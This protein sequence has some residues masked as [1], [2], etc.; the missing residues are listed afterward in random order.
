LTFFLQ[1]Q[2]DLQTGEVS[3]ENVHPSQTPIPDPVILNRDSRFCEAE[4]ERSEGPMHSE[5]HF[6][7]VYIMTN[8]SKT[9]Y[10]G[11]TGYLERR[12]FEHKQE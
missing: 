4:T 3:S 11:V 12:A 2:D 9:L 5:P 6:Y 7:Y 10:T 1:L 8:R